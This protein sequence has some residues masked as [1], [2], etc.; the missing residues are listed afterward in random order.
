MLF[1]TVREFRDKATQ[2]LRQKEPV[3][4]TRDGKP[5]GFFIPWEHSSMQDDIR[6]AVLEALAESLRQQREKR[7][8]TEEEVLD[9][10]AAHRQA[11]RG[12]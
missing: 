2:V 5:A 11:R 10:F 9:D 4:V 8:I 3:L 1:V 6:K 12:R 7:G